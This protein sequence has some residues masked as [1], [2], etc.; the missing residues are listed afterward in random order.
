L[1]CSIASSKSRRKREEKLEL[2]AQGELDSDRLQNPSDPDATH[3][4]KGGKDNTGYSCNIVEVRDPEKEAG[5][6]LEYKIDNNLHSGQDYGETFLR[7][8]PLADEI[9]TLATDGAYHRP[10]SHTIAESKN[11][12]WNVSNIP[13]RASTTI[14]VDQFVRNDDHLI[15]A[16]PAGH[17]PLKASY[18]AEAYTYKAKFEKSTCASCPLLNQCPTQ[19][20]KRIASIHFTE[21]KL[22]TDRAR[23]RL[24]TERHKELSNFRAGVEGVVSA[25]KRGLIQL[26]VR[27]LSRVKIWIHGRITRLQLESNNSTLAVSIKD[28]TKKYNRNIRTNTT[29][30]HP[31]LLGYF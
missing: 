19:Q 9:E 7:N 17:T 24:G 5:M 26:P 10:K 1:P 8:S 18:D 30:E 22:Q 20:K 28:Q 6:I 4:V 21:N 27:G 31:I 29:A 3:R 14:G 11:I 16:C 12:E 25:V 15:T 23:N 2:K 13:G